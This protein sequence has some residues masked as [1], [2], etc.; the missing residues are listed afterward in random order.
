[1]QVIVNRI[2]AT[3]NIFTFLTR[4]AVNPMRAFYVF[5][6]MDGTEV[7]TIWL[8]ANKMRTPIHTTQES[9]VHPHIA[10]TIILL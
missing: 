4:E 8:V 2:T 9:I 5:E 3:S 7:R 1:M 10:L 6:R